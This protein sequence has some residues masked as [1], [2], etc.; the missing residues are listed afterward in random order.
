[1]QSLAD[2]ESKIASAEEKGLEKGL[3]Q[4]REEGLAEG[5]NQATQN[6]ALC[7]A[8]EGAAIE[9]IAKVTGLPESE[10]KQLLQKASEQ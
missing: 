10:I 9:I 4:G 8:K 3:E 5:I 2:V 6:I 7:L 1:M